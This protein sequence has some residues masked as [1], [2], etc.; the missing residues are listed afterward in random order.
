MSRW[1]KSGVLD[2]VFAKLQQ[3]QILTVKFDVFSL[4]STGVKVHP[5]GTG[6]LK[7]MEHKPLGCL[8]EVATP[9]FIWWLLS[10]AEALPRMTG[11]R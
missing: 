10:E 11:L 7:N 9:K 8:A 1:A 6:A 2:Q 4:D 3:Q 5:D